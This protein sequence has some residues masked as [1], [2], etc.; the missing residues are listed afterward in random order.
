CVRSL[1]PINEGGLYLSARLECSADFQR[2]NDSA[3]KLR[4]Y[5][6]TKPEDAGYVE[7]NLPSCGKKPFQALAVVHHNACHRQPVCSRLRK[8][9]AVL[10]QQVARCGLQKGFAAGV[11]ALLHQKIYLL[12]FIRANGDIKFLRL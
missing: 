1:G 2:L 12:K 11:E 4:S 3:G 6:V 5:V 9:H 10:M 7:F 8:V